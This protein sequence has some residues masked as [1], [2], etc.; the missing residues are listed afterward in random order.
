M[1][2][3]QHRRRTEGTVIYNEPGKVLFIQE[4]AYA[5]RIEPGGDRSLMLGDRVEV[6]GFV[7]SSHKVAGLGGAIIRKIGS[8]P[9]QV[10]VPITWAEIETDYEQMRWGKPMRFPGLDGLLV[11]VTGR[12]IGKL[13]Q[14]AD[15][16]T[17]LELDC[18]DS[19]TTAFVHGATGN[20]RPGTELR[21]TGVAS[22]QYSPSGQV[23]DFPLPS[24]LD[25]LLRDPGDL[26]VLRAASW[27]TR[28]RMYAAMGILLAGL[29]AGA[30]WIRQLQRVVARQ[31]KRWERTLRAHRDSELEMKEAREERYRL[32]GDLHDGLQQ[33]L[34]GASF[35]LEAALLRLGDQ[36]PEV[37]EQFSATR[38]ALERTRTGLRECLL[39]L[40][41]VEEGPA[42]FTALLRHAAGKMEH[43]PKGAVEIVADGEPFPLSRHVM[44]TLRLFMQ[45][46]V[47]NAFKHGA[48]SHVRVALRYL[49][50]SLEMHIN[51]DGSGFEPSLAPDSTA[52]HFGVES[53]R[54]RLR[55]LG[56]SAEFL[57]KPGE[58]TRV[59]A[60]L[61][62]KTAE[63]HVDSTEFEQQP[64]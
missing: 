24:R 60:R 62:R 7:D 48:A 17:R 13:D 1:G 3:P 23:L 43:W 28:E 49:P 45:E 36:A 19:T 27:W 59:I 20:L 12:L 34:T 39:G 18:G 4:G 42:E 8:S 64:S 9:Q 61:A 46:A 44:G 2:T 6:T 35:R 54:H 53:M 15:G 37:N 21:A 38:A 50:E 55:W 32:A 56:G 57:S 30:L 25:Q 11:S 26:T 31:T 14:S 63:E 5:V 52:R 40:R 10:P 33:H 29:A 58:G 16:V 51:D 22:V 47:A 41:S